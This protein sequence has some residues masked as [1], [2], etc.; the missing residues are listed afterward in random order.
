MR[1]IFRVQFLLV[2]LSVSLA[3]HAQWLDFTE[4]TCTNLSLSSVAN[5]DDEEKD[6]EPADLNNDGFTDLIV[7]RKEPFSNPTEPAK[8]DLLLMNVGGQLVDQTALYAPEFI[9]NPTYA[10]DVFIG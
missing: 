5:S 8:S 3:G 7:V 1:S 4:I 9:E 2:A 10:R 6:M